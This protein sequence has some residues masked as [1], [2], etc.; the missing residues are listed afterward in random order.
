[1]HNN[2][3]NQFALLIF[4]LLLTLIQPAYSKSNK[5]DADKKEAS[6]S[7]ATSEKSPEEKAAIAKAIEHYNQ[8]CK[9]ASKKQYTQAIDEFQQAVNAYPSEPHLYYN[10]ALANQ[11]AGKIEEAVK[12]YKKALDLNPRYGKCYVNLGYIF[13]GLAKFDEALVFYQSA[14]E[15]K[16]S[17]DVIKGVKKSIKDIEKDKAEM[18]KKAEKSKNK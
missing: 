16:L 1:M 15:C 2:K 13:Y 6:K 12:T 17:P 4:A 5:T 14:L 8:G 3:T 10:L 9:L 7:S 18:A 11:D